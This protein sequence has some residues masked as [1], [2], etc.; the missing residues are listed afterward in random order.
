MPT[1]SDP[2][3]GS[4][5]LDP[6]GAADALDQVNKLV[7]GF[8]RMGAAM[9]VVAQNSGKVA[10]T[11][12]PQD[13]AAL[14]AH[15]DAVK[16]STSAA[17]G[18]MEIDKELVKLQV[19]K[20][21][22]TQKYR[23]A[24]RDEIAINAAAADSLA[25]MRIKLRELNKEYDQAAASSRGQLSPAI[26]E[27]TQKINDAEQ[28]TGR[29]Q[30]NVG[31]YHDNT[32]KYAKGLRG[33]GGLGRLAARIFGFDTEGFHDIQ[34]AGAALKEYH[35]A[36]EAA[37][38]A[39]EGHAAAEGAD[40][41]QIELNTIAEK[42]NSVAKN[43]GFGLIGLLALTVGSAIAIYKAWTD[44]IKANDEELKKSEKSLREYESATE[45]LAV[46]AE[47][48][49][50]RLRVMQGTLTKGAADRKEAKR[51]E[52]GALLKEQEK[53]LI[54]R[55]QKQKLF[56]KLQKGYSESWSQEQKDQLTKA[57]DDQQK[58]EE[59]HQKAIQAIKHKY[60]I[61]EGLIHAEE[62]KQDKKKIEKAKYTNV[63]IGKIDEQFLKEKKAQEEKARKDHEDAVKFMEKISG[64]NLSDKGPQEVQKHEQ[65]VEL[66]QNKWFYDH[67]LIDLK[68]Y[69]EA[70]KEIKAH[71]AQVEKEEQSKLRKEIADADLNA[72][73]ELVNQKNTL[74]QDALKTQTEMLSSE[75]QVQATLA[76]AGKRNSLDSTLKAQNQAAQQEKDLARKAQRDQ[77]AIALSKLFIDS[78]SAFL[79]AGSTPSQAIAKA[80]EQVFLTKGIAAGLLGA[81]FEGTS[82]TGGPGTIDKR[83]GKL[84]IIHPNEAIIPKKRNEEMPGLAEAWINGDLD[85]YFAQMYFPKLPINDAIKPT[86]Q[87][88]TQEMI[89]SAM[90]EALEDM[91][92]NTS[93]QHGNDTI[94][95]EYRGGSKTT[96]IIK[97]DSPIIPRNR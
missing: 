32:I 92:M 58:V 13:T 38:V 50:D 19:E 14:K 64:R 59:T 7:D 55:F 72:L 20:A 93:Y 83:G 88:L 4:D 12:I 86:Q 61:D 3:L 78:E 39:A 79:K 16:Q 54:E 24:V 89:T 80:L 15:T 33:L 34:E 48:A 74:Q 11:G 95:E 25:A 71:Y 49:E 28:A 69:L 94:I 76:A 35:H 6:Q 44:E 40:T 56:D 37:K 66:E 65:A 57:Y 8:E 41:A 68:T 60:R 97:G 43:I 27:L 82:D 84:A 87:Q 18:K 62:L 75:A 70:E 42:E 5:I 29:F 52:E 91:P 21:T 81:F 73:S 96:R 22:A 10:K 17:R 90:S 36:Q 67:K 9:K 47:K 63:E 1:Q 30:R 26:Q 2:L 51:E 46:S 77:E 85:S 31:N 23:Q 45:E 53:Y